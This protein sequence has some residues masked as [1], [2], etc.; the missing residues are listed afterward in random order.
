MPLT[1]QDVEHIASLARLELTEEEKE[2]FT[3]E[4]SSILDYF[5]QLKEVDTEKVEPTYQVTGLE[6]VMRKDKVEGCEEE[7]RNDSLD[8]FPEKVKDFLKV[9]GVFGENGDV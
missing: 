7:V 5:E 9:K 6:N 3:K 1:K 4:L 8:Q 2:K